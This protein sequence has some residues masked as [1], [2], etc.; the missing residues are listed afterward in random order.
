MQMQR[1]LI[2]VHRLLVAVLSATAGRGSNGPRPSNGIHQTYGIVH[3]RPAVWPIDGPNLNRRTTAAC[4]VAVVRLWKGDESC[5][6][7]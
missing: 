3:T 6:E 7:L 2:E 4:N 5:H 1:T